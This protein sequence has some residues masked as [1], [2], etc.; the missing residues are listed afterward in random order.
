MDAEFVGFVGD[1]ADCTQLRQKGPQ[2]YSKLPY[3]SLNISPHGHPTPS[4]AVTRDMLCTFQRTDKVCAPPSED[5]QQRVSVKA[6]EQALRTQQA[7]GPDRSFRCIEQLYQGRVNSA[8]RNQTGHCLKLL[9][10]SAN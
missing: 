4:G 9:R 6:V 3:G 10:S 2:R 1:F 5:P 7:A 8:R